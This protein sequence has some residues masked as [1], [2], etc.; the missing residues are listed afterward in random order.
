[1]EIFEDKGVVIKV[2]IILEKEE[3]KEVE[4]EEK[5]IIVVFKVES[6]GNIF[7]FMMID[8]LVD[9]EVELKEECIEKN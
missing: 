9:F 5:N 6:G 4:S 8:V 1:M 2:V 7:Y 3:I